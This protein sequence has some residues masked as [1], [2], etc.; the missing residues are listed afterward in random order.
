MPHGQEIQFSAGLQNCASNNF[1]WMLSLLPSKSIIKWNYYRLQV[2]L[3]CWP[4][5]GGN[6]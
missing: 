3:Q 1:N 6:R 4:L 2:H 5:T